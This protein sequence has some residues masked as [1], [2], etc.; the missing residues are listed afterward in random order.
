METNG[1]GPLHEKRVLVTGATGFL[2]SHLCKR[3]S[4][5][6][7]RVL[8]VS[9]A[10]RRAPA[11]VEWTQD[12]LASPERVVEIFRELR[13]EV[14]YH[15]AGLATGVSGLDMVEPTFQ[16]LVVSTKNVL[17]AAARAGGPRVILSGS[18]EEPQH[19]AEAPVSPYAA[20]KLAASAYGR[21]FNALYGVPVVNFRVFM[22]YGPNQH[23]NKIVP[24]VITSLLRGAPPELASGRR[25]V[26]WI[27]VDDVIEGMVSAATASG[28]EGATIDLGSGR[29][30]TIREMVEAIARA[31]RPD[32]LPRF[33]AVP[34]RPVEATRIADPSTA[35]RLMGWEPRTSI[36]DGIARTVAWYREQLAAEGGIS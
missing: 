32:V 24:Y 1:N 27:Y 34:D 12:D 22:T 30:V 5:L 31:I 8:G 13:P 15:L 26:D 35:Q 3:L 20:A 4:D 21:L 19:L 23:R 28:V 11:Y 2:G 6:G 36:D 14:V 17:L 18:L 9:R 29:L 10:P 7:A 33:G 16:S 25:Q